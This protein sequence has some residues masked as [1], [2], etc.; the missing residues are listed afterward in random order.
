MHSVAEPLFEMLAARTRSVR[1][2]LI[3]GGGFAAVEA[4]L[5]FDALAGDRLDSN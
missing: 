3:T 4:M 2:V 1:R 5:A